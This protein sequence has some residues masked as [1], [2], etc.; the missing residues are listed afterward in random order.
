MKGGREP[1]PHSEKKKEKGISAAGGGTTACGKKRK[2]KEKKG[3]RAGG[4]KVRG[5][6]ASGWGAGGRPIAGTEGEKGANSASRAN[7]D[8]LGEKGGEE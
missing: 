8:R 3:K 7:A 6:S 2:G 1:T 5:G 4:R